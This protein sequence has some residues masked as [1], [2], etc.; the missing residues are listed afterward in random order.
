MIKK[1]LTFEDFNGETVTEDFYFH[2]SEADIAKQEML[3]SFEGGMEEKLRKAIEKGDAQTIIDLF[4]FIIKG[5]IGEKSP[6]GKKFF[7]NQE[8]TDNFVASNAYSVLFMELVTDAV[9][10]ANFINGVVP[11]NLADQ[12]KQQDIKMP[13]LKGMS[14]TSMMVDEVKKPKSGRMTREEILAGMRKK[15][16]PRVLE[17]KDI[18]EMSQ[19]ELDSEL[20]AGA[21]IAE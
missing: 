4:E 14:P 11:A 2:I 6:D 8:I 15:T 21:I 5:S 12:I 9:K 18:V 20:E 10:G 1:T 16:Q 3:A 7:K 13:A 17:Y 19:E